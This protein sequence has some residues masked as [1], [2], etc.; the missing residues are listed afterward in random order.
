MQRAIIV[1]HLSWTNT[2]PARMSVSCYQIRPRLVSYSIESTPEQ[3]SRAAAEAFCTALGRDA[4]RL[5]GGTLDKRRDVY[6]F[7]QEPTA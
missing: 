2:K 3:D 1:K 5:V 6:T 4:S 7:R